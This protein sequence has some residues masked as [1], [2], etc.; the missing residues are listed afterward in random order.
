MFYKGSLP[1]GFVTSPKISDIYLSFFDKNRENTNV[2]VTRYSDDILLST[3]TE[4]LS[5]PFDLLSE[6]YNIIND[7][8]K[9]GLKINS[10]KTLKKQL[11]NYGD[12]IKFLGINIVKGYPDNR[13]TISDKYIRDTCK[14]YCNYMNQKDILLFS[15]VIGKIH[16]IKNTSESSFNKFKRLFEIKT[17]KKFEFIQYK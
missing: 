7:L 2:I 8:K 10:H 4:S 1:I 6:Y 16:Y 14:E 5:F 12:S 3:W 17:G 15:K 13:I 9:I 11:I